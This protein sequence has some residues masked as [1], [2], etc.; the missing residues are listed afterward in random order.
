MKTAAGSDETGKQPEFELV[1]STEALQAITTA[2]INQQVATA[3]AYPRSIAKFIKTATDMVQASQDIAKKCFY[4]LERTNADGTKKLITGPSVRFTEIITAA[5]EHITVAS[6]T[7]A[8]EE[9]Y[10]VAQGLA[11]DAERNVRAV[12]EVRRRIT[13]RNGRRFG[14][15][16]INL[17]CNAAASIAGRNAVAKI[18][19]MALCAPILEAA[20]LTSRGEMKDLAQRREKCV[21]AFLQFKLTEKQLCAYLGVKGMADV[22]LDELEVLVG[23]FNRL[24]D[25]DLTP[26]DVLLEI[27]KKQA[28][29]EPASVFGSVSV[30]GAKK[31]TPAAP[32]QPAAP[33]KAPAPTTEPPQSEPA[34]GEDDGNSSEDREVTIEEARH[35]INACWTIEG[36]KE[37]R[38]LCHG[39][40]DLPK[41]G[42]PKV[43]D[44]LALEKTNGDAFA[45]LVDRIPAKYFPVAPAPVAEPEGGNISTAKEPSKDEIMLRL[46]TAASLQTRLTVKSAVGAAGTAFED[47]LALEEDDKSD[48]IRIF[49]KMAQ[50]QAAIKGSARQ[51]GA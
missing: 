7:V 5:Y 48:A 19:P 42:A 9:K 41:K 6:R 47:F 37:L 10:V 49:T 2:E 40:I 23:L 34:S 3:R 51:Q 30:G 29:G 44:V 8:I 39:V 31:S 36:S 32:T 24:E 15:D 17:T 38:S 22:G 16:M 20:R 21:A 4:A 14:D 33:Q 46:F 43:D 50:P 1:K 28:G 18:I 25:S 12:V 26:N 35:A 45:L 27:E 13:D 11:Y